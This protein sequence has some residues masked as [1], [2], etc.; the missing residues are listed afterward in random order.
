MAG[1]GSE[2][3]VSKVGGKQSKMRGDEGG[4]EMRM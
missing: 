3:V 2:G 4:L 1:R